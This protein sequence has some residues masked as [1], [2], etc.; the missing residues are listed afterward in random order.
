MWS[1]PLS[2][3]QPFS[4]ARAR[5]EVASYGLGRCPQLS[6]RLPAASLVAACERARCVVRAMKGD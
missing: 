4:P 1:A 3:P 2:P 6:C 5:G